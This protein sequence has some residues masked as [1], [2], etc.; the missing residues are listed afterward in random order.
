MEKIAAI[1]K[2]FHS[3]RFRRLR[4]GATAFLPVKVE[5]TPAASR[6]AYGSKMSTATLD[7]ATDFYLNEISRPGLSGLPLKFSR[8]APIRKHLPFDRILV[9]SVEGFYKSP[10]ASPW[11]FGGIKCFLSNQRFRV[12][13]KIPIL[14]KRLFFTC[15]LS[16]NKYACMQPIKIVPRPANS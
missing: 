14:T 15:F 4:A 6:R 10:L 5:I 7:L 11:S 9:A 13:A 2:M 3:Q 16:I 12:K 1:S 8:L